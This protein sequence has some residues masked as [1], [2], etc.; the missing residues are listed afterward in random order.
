MTRLRKAPSAAIDGAKAGKKPLKGNPTRPFVLGGIV[1]LAVVLHQR[2]ALHLTFSLQSDALEGML[3]TSQGDVS[4]PRLDWK[5][6]LYRRLDIIKRKCGVL[7]TLN[8]PEEIEPY[9]VSIPNW[10]LWKPIRIPGWESSVGAVKATT[11]KKL[12]SPTQCETFMSMEEVDA[13]DHTFP[14][15]IPAEL[16]TKLFIR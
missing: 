11:K 5:R 16:K 9:E 15:D 13:A 8:S 12:L 4:D 1:A 3:D 2:E 6:Q 10:S 14:L 7:C